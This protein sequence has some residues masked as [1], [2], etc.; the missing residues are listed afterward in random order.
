MAM[1][2]IYVPIYLYLEGGEL[3]GKA[4]EGL[5]LV[6]GFYGLQRI[7]T[8][9]SLFPLSKM[10]EKVGFRKSISLSVI[11]LVGYMGGLY[12]SQTSLWWLIGA[13]LCG[14]IQTTVYWLSRDSALS[15]DIRS[16]AM[17]SRMGHIGALENIAGLLGPFVG[18]VI[19]AIYGYSTLFA[20]ALV[21]IVMSALPLWW[22]PPHAHKNGVSIAGFWQFLSDGRYLHQAVA[23]FATAMNDYGNGI[24]W[25][26]ILFIQ[27]MKSENLGAVY[28]LVAVVMVIVHYLAG[29][30]FD[31]LRAKRDYADEGVYGLA[32]VGMAVAW[33]GRMF[34]TGF[35]Q[36]LPVDLGRQIFASVYANFYNDYTHLGGKRMGSIAFWVYMQAIY[37]FGALFLFGLMAIG[38][39]FGVWKEL[40]LA[41]IALWSLVSIVVARES[42]M[43]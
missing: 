36:V 11:F 21:I 22:M 6:V 9:M 31:K 28:S 30:W 8:L 24:I 19:V 26:L 1:T 17:G 7:L 41:T 25:P 12:L 4:T 37:S 3:R 2:T 18:G 33:V 38:I 5:L 20:V 35:A 10:V 13:A 40:A 39:Y 16:N 23:N 32:T 15:Q 14:S 27:G 42:N 34:V 29:A 43:R